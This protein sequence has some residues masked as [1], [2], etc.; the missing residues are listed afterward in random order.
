M[1]WESTTLASP[2]GIQIRDSKQ[3]KLE[4][5]FRL[6]TARPPP[7]CR[8]VTT[9]FWPF[10]L[11]PWTSRQTRQPS[12]PTEASTKTDHY[13]INGALFHFQCLLHCATLMAKW[14]PACSLINRLRGKPVTSLAP[15]RS[16]ITATI[17]RPVWYFA[18]LP[19]ERYTDGRDLP[20]LEEDPTP[21]LEGMLS[22]A[23]PA[24]PL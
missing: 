12:Q 20:P 22:V 18:A 10:I 21:L 15:S 17:L 1:P 6:P 2:R 9:S 24:T 16:R 5:G 11:R 7:T 3:W 13:S 4:D 8:P 23:L 19:E 14:S